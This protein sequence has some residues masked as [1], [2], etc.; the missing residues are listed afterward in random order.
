[1]NPCSIVI[2]I[3]LIVALQRMA[4]RQLLDYLII[5]AARIF[6]VLNKKWK[7]NK[8]NPWSWS[9]SSIQCC[10]LLQS[11]VYMYKEIAASQ[12]RTPHLATTSPESSPHHATLRPAP[13]K[14][15]AATRES[16]NTGA[17]TNSRSR[18]SAQACCPLL[19][20]RSLVRPQQTVYLLVSAPRN[21][22]IPVI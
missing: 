5:F 17:S 3:V 4:K 20:P 21:V 2:K 11:A 18:E 12:S 22:F 13:G 14:A 15:E 7:S 8:K 6:R 16:A 1:M 9:S 10:I 19:R